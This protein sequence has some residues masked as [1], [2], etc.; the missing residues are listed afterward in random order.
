MRALTTALE[1]LALV[2][3]VAGVWLIY[4]PAAVIAAGL[5]LAGLSYALTASRPIEVTPGTDDE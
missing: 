5:A 4:I 1:C 2:L 3:I